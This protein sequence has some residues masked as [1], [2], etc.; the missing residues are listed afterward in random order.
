MFIFVWDNFNVTFSAN[1]NG[2]KFIYLP[3]VI[4]QIRTYY[5]KLSSLYTMFTASFITSASVFMVKKLFKLFH[6][7]FLEQAS[8][9][10]GVL[11]AV[12]LLKRCSN[13]VQ[14]RWATKSFSLTLS[15]ILCRIIL[16]CK[17]KLFSYYASIHRGSHRPARVINVDF[18]AALQVWEQRFLSRANSLP[19]L[20]STTQQE[21]FV[22]SIKVF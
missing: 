21:R 9:F 20:Q 8:L 12:D 19:L 18:C 2:M 6:L 17:E 1:L 4:T 16:L 22:E 10:A 11:P 5:L 13:A 3:H 7:N 15:L 14:C